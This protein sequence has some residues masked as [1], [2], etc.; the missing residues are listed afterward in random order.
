[1]PSVP[2]ESMH[3]LLPSPCDIYT[4]A[5]C[6]LPFL[7]RHPNT[8]MGVAIKTLLDQRA[9]EAGIPTSHIAGSFFPMASHFNEDVEIFKE[10]FDALVSG[11]QTLDKDVPKDVWVS[12]NEY[13]KTTAWTKGA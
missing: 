2:S 4:D 6:S 8:A 3:T 12:A 7:N 11:L 9:G 13:I 1:M 5:S 10:F